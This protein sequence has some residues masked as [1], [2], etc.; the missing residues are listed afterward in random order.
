MVI[1][2]KL[3]DLSMCY[4]ISL[5]EYAGKEYCLSA[6]EER[7]GGIVM[8]DTQTKEVAKITGLAGGVMAMIPI[9]EENGAFLAIQKFYPIFDSKGAEVVYCRI[10]GEVKEEMEA[11]VK[12]VACI[13]FVHRIALVG[14]PGNRSM[15][16]ATLCKD[17]DFIEDWSKPGSVYL[18]RLNEQFKPVEIIVLQEG[19]YKNHGMYTYQK[20]GGYYTMI[21]G[22]EGIWAIDQQYHM[23]HICQE[24]VSDLCLYDVDGD[25]VDEIVCITPF[26]GDHLNIFK[27]IQGGWKVIADEPISFGHAVWAGSCA[28]APLILSC[29][30]GG[31]KCTRIYRPEIETGVLRMPSVDVDENAGASNI[32]V[33]EKDGLVILYAANHGINEVARYT[34]DLSL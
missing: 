34:I 4:S 25:G 30:R 13:P 8:I 17:K 31:D 1:K 2:E 15:I 18:Y 28:G 24:S 11:E 23:P 12:L 22:Q 10:S 6:S 20:Q 7:D 26:H 33:K 19:I 16:A 9:P 5:M 29:S 32:A 14:T 27:S 21:A 3:A